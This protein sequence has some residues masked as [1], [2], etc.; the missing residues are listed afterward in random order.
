[1]VVGDEAT[2]RL[3]RSEGEAIRCQ[4]QRRL[5]RPIEGLPADFRAAVRR[6]R[7]GALS[8]AQDHPRIGSFWLQRT[9]EGTLELSDTLA[10]TDHAR[11]GL[12]VRFERRG[13]RWRLV[14]VSVRIAHARRGR[15]AQ[16]SP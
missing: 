13:E 6:R 4:L 1:M 2:I 15:S 5:R 7:V 14:D 8:M 11:I 10:M 3:T 9:S 12:V 16:P